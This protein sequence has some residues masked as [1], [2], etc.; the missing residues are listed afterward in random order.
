MN[1][2]C[3]AG[4]LAKLKERKDRLVL[5]LVILGMNVTRPAGVFENK[6]KYRDERKEGREEGGTNERTNERM[7]E[8][9]KQESKRRE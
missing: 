4:W 5:N 1:Y 9:M 7:N 8:D 2:M 6:E 3:S